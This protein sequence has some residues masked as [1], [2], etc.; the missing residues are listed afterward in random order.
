MSI[1]AFALAAFL[2]PLPAFAA[3]FQLK[4][5]PPAVGTMLNGFDELCTATLVNDDLVLTAAHCLFGD[6]GSYS[7]PQNFE[8][9]DPVTGERF[10]TGIRSVF[11]P[12]DFDYLSWKDT[13]DYNYR[14][15]AL[16]QILEPISNRVTPLQV[17]R[18]GHSELQEAL[19]QGYGFVGFGA[20]DGETPTVYRNCTVKE[21]N[22]D[23]TFIDDCGTVPGDSGGPAIS[24]V[25]GQ[26]AVVGTVSAEMDN[27]DDLTVA[28]V[29]FSDA[30]H[31]FIHD[32]PSAAGLVRMDPPQG[33]WMIEMQG[34]AS[35]TAVAEGFAVWSKDEKGMRP[36]LRV[37]CRQG[38]PEVAVILPV[39]I[40]SKS[41]S[42]EI[43]FDF[44]NSPDQVVVAQPGSMTIIPD[45]EGK[46]RDALALAANGKAS[47]DRQSFSLRYESIY[48]VRT[49]MA[50]SLEGFQAAE[51]SLGAQCP[52]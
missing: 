39:P 46:L 30:I 21:W 33:R 41:G 25:D 9:R 17:A 48:G 15:W 7:F 13:E 35:E 29:S 16:I 11:L 40:L 27:S 20:T 10:T 18:A 37:V 23:G 34:A 22:L 32:G 47:N 24:V 38:E 51:N 50:F 6:D 1:R 12:P 28:S 8:V 14:D 4:E 3:S 43:R 31:A 5:A 49:R 26:L 36:D 42:A 45:P 2:L 52:R 19:S 44:K